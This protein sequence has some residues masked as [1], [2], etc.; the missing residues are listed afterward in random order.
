VKVKNLQR[1]T[2]DERVG[3]NEPPKIADCRDDD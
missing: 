1:G 2:A 3:R